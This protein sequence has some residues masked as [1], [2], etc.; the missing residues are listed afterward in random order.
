MAQVIDVSI[1]P[2]FAILILEVIA[3]RHPICM[4]DYRGT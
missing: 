1:V 2:G 3:T 4:D